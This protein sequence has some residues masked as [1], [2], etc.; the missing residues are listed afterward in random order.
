MTPSAAGT[1]PWPA[2]RRAAPRALVFLSAFAGL[3]LAWQHLQG[4]AVQ[5]TF[6]HTLTARPAAAL[7]GLLLPTAHVHADGLAVAGDGGRLNIINGC[8][9]VEAV[10]LLAGALLAAPASWMARA[11]GLALGTVLVVA[12]NQLRVAVLFY[13]WC[14]SPA[15]FYVLHGT[16]TPIGLILVVAAYFYAWSAHSARILPA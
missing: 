2:L 10:F 15:W 13:A 11:Q 6:V 14:R 1:T 5:Y 9:G 16:V 4:S 8:E 7:L 3:Q 12:V